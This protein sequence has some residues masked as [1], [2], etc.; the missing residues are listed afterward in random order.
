MLW[1][2]L[3][4]I[5]VSLQQD[6]ECRMSVDMLILSHIVS[7]R[8]SVAIHLHRVISKNLSH[9]I[10]SHSLIISHKTKKKTLSQLRT[11][12]SPGQAWRRHTEAGGT[13]WKAEGARLFLLSEPTCRANFLTACNRSN[14]HKM[15][16]QLCNLK[17]E[18]CKRTP[19]L[20]GTNE[21]R[22]VSPP[23]PRV[24]LA[25]TRIYS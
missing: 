2:L 15:D 8:H 16:V 21:M 9:L 12:F 22:S 13:I 1:W 5:D 4:I 6:I 20:Q 18:T 3:N 11:H 17:S 7:H 19:G 24:Q 23:S 25:K 10:E 14:S